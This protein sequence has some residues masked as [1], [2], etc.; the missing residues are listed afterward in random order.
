MN[1]PH[2]AGHR[3]TVD[4]NDGTAI[5]RSVSLHALGRQRSVDDAYSEDER[6]QLG[7]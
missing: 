2:I 1:R 3:T 6:E 7:R 5:D 4:A